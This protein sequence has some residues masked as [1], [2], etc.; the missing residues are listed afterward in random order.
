MDCKSPIKLRK[1]KLSNGAYSLYLD[2]YDHGRRQTESLGLYINPGTDAVTKA[3]NK[4]ALAAAN[5]I[6]ARRLVEIQETGNG[7]R[8]AT[9]KRVSMLDLMRQYRESRN[10][11]SRQYMQILLRVEA[12]WEQYAGDRVKIIHVDEKK[13]LGFIKYVS[14]LPIGRTSTYPSTSTLELYYSVMCS[15]LNYA[16]SKGMIPS[17]PTLRI[18]R[19]E[20]P[21][22]KPKSMRQYLTIEELRRLAA[23]DCGSPMTKCAFMLAC[24]TGLRI[25][26]IKQV[27]W[28]MIEQKQIRLRMQKTSGEIVIP[29]TEKAL[30]WVPEE[31]TD[32]MVFHLPSNQAVNIDIK[33]WVKRAGIEKPITFHCSRHTFA[34]LLISSNVD[35]YTVSKLLGHSKVTT[36]AIY[37]KITDSKRNEAIDSLPEL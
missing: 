3:A 36:T 31:R 18:D 32:D 22:R 9:A 24:Y 11:L 30:A 33:R 12:L 2:W 10:G 6:L 29:L 27:T 26:D 16:V 13:V 20:K 4:S 25:S 21:K 5:V 1:R 17:S 35:I 19:N 23:T 14:E 15:L 7:L 37:A 34:T 28:A 8:S